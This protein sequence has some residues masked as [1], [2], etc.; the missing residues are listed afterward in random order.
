[1]VSEDRLAADE[2]RQLAG[3]DWNPELFDKMKGDDGCVSMDQLGW[4]M[5][6]RKENV[7]WM[8]HF[9]Q[10]GCSCDDKQR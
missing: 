5:R 8:H 9:R 3:D 7:V 4:C 2:V 6:Q 10:E 1:M